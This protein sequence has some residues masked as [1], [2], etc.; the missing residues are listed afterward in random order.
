MVRTSSFNRAVANPT[1]APNREHQG[2]L[3][4]LAS[5]SRHPDA[6][7]LASASY[8]DQQFGGIVPSFL[9]VNALVSVP[10]MKEMSAGRPVDTVLL[11]YQDNCCL[12]IGTPPQQEEGVRAGERTENGGQHEQ[13]GTKIWSTSCK[14]AGGNNSDHHCKFQAS[15]ARRRLR[16]SAPAARGEQS[17]HSSIPSHRRWK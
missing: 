10:F 1:G 16:G 5:A 14:T 15:N 2:V 3:P 9:V 17:E 11:L 8:P 12:A 6:L 4:A 7:A 13:N